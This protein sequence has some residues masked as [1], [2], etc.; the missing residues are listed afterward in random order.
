MKKEC[1]INCKKKTKHEVRK[2]G[3]ARIIL[4]NIVFIPDVTSEEKQS[5]K[6]YYPLKKSTTPYK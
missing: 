3:C 1:D 6:D 2:N 4:W 5:L